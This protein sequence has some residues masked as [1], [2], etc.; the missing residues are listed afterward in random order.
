MGLD[1]RKPD[2][3][4]CEQQRHRSDGACAQTGQHLR[5]TFLNLDPCLR[6]TCTRGDQKVRGKVL[7][8]RIVFIDCNDYSQTLT[9]FLC[10]WTEIKI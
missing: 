10:K 2:F 8:N 1:A 7:L 4:A 9:V 5:N 6:D 3:V